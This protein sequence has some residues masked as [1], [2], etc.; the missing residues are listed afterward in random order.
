MSIFAALKCLVIRNLGSLMKATLGAD[1]APL[2][3]LQNEY[4]MLMAERDD[5]FMEELKHIRRVA[6]TF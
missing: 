5:T 4:D 6:A 2:L 3:A 1:A